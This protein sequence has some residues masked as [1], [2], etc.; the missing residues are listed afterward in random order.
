MQRWHRCGGA[1][2]GIGSAV[3]AFGALA[4]D[5]HP[6]CRIAIGV[7]DHRLDFGIGR[8]PGAFAAVPDHH[9]PADG[10][11]GRITLRIIIDDN[12][13]RAAAVFDDL[14]ILDD[15]GADLARGGSRWC[16]RC[17]GRR[18][19]RGLHGSRWQRCHRRR[20]GRRGCRRSWRRGRCAGS[21]DHK[22]CRDKR[23]GADS[24]P[25]ATASREVMVF[26][27]GNAFLQLAFCI[28]GA[29]GNR[30]R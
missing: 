26:D 13:G 15:Q 24:A 11:A 8:N 4:G 17:D 27:H 30:H 9:H 20:R 6:V 23:C 29:G 18:R 1:V 7:A 10:L 14:A 22:P 12:C 5:D 25:H 19:R 21:S 2:F 28:H 16:W 3:R